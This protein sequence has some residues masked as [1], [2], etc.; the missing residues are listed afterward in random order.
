MDIV[1]AVARCLVNVLCKEPEKGNEEYVQQQGQAQI[2]LGTP[3]VS[4]F[5][6]PALRPLLFSVQMCP[7]LSIL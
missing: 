6:T 3:Y 4:I 2:P 1:I 7:I 5:A